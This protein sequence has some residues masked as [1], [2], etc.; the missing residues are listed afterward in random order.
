MMSHLLLLTYRSVNVHLIHLPK[1]AMGIV[2][3]TEEIFVAVSNQLKTVFFVSTATFHC[4]T[5]S[6]KSLVKVEIDVV[7]V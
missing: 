6:C 7:L 5:E 4:S 1:N 3:H 2:V